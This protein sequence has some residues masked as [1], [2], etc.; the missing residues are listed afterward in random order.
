[1]SKDL[2]II[3]RLKQTIGKQLAQVKHPDYNQ[4]SYSIDDNLNV[5]F[6]SLHECQ[7]EQFPKEIIALKNLQHLDLFD[8]QLALLHKY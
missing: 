3:F 6:L 8:N 1:M 2:D 5:T 4:A 7:L